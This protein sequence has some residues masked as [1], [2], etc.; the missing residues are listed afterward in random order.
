MN[1]QR[2]LVALLLTGL[3]SAFFYFDLDRYFDIALF[4]EQRDQ[5]IKS[6][7]QHSGLFL[8][9]YFAVYVLATTLSL[10]GATLLTLF[11]GALFGFSLALLLVSFASSLGALCAFQIARYLLRDWV[12]ERFPKQTQAIDAGV[13]REGAFY[14]FALRL[15]PLFPFFMINL[16]MGLTSLGAWRFYW[17][18]QIGMLVGTAVYVNAGT[19]LRYVN[20]LGDIVSPQL[21][22]SFALLGLFPLLAKKA[23]EYIKARMALREFKK[24]KRFDANL[25]VIGA[26]SAG[27]VSAYLAAAAKAKVYLIE[28]HKMGGDCLNT[29]C[30]P[31]KSF[32]RSANIMRYIRRAAEFGL[33]DAGARVDFAAVMSRVENIITRIEPHDSV[34]RYTELGVEC[35]SGE[36]RI[37]SPYHVEVNGKRLSARAIIIASGAEPA[38]PEIP[39]LADIPCYTSETFWNLREQ[40]GHVLVLGGGP[41]GCEL[42]QA[43]RG[44]GSRVSMIVSKSG[45]MPREDDDVAEHIS[46]VFQQQGIE[47][48]RESRVLGFHNRPNGYYCEIS[49]SAGSVQTLGFDALL[50]AT[51]RRARQQ[52]LGLENLPFAYNDD[53]SLYT[54]E[55]LRTSIPGIYACGDIIGPYQFTHMAA[56][57]AWYATMNALFGHIKKFRVDYSVVPWATF[58]QP[59]VARV[60]L[61]EREAQQQNIAY[62][63]THYGIDDL[64]R[65]IADAEASGFIKVLTVPGKDTILGVGI[66]GYHASELINEFILAMRHGLGLRKILGTIHIY[67][68]LSEANK[69]SA[70]AWQRAHTPQGLMRLVQRYHAWRRG[71]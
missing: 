51:G 64:D 40:P 6:Y 21:L 62:E 5:L 26:G 69:F 38:I 66:V 48:H 44:L 20:E 28:K 63:L 23:L 43:L 59:E 55:Y 36:A 49:D 12:R 50:L 56:H 37:V 45:L 41:I 10:P 9:V 1:K 4:V 39:G 27:L 29:G 14:L 11:A 17:V 8:L 25:I 70:G 60:G 52:G 67:P 22:V 19:Q 46:N 42:A 15:V 24:P 3:V 13:A 31:S 30:V 35:I 32:I 57:Q 34:A 33:L 18:S 53:G 54:D 71:A 7:E 58:T 2:L 68:T 16:L 47:L 65:A 61:N